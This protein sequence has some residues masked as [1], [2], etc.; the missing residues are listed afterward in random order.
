M[1]FDLCGVRRLVVQYCGCGG[2][3]DSISKYTQLLRVRWFPAT[4][5]R[6]STVFS[7]NMLDFFHKL[8]NQN[9]CNLYD[10]Y[11]TIIQRADAAGLDSEIVCFLIIVPCFLVHPCAVLV[12]RDHIGV[13]HLEPPPAPQTSWFCPPFQRHSVHT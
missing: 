1:V 3:T 6:P 5:E 12:Q 2:F 4:I 9:K 13:S 7:F 10:F 11:H 8:Q